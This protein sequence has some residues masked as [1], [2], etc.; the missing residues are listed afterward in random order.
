M[1]D[2]NSVRRFGF[3]GV[4]ASQ[5]SING[6]FPRWVDVWQL[7]D[8]T[9]EPHDVPL[10]AR[11]ERYRDIVLAIRD[12]PRHVGA[13]VTSHKVRL[14]DATRDLFDELDEHAELC[15]EVSCISKRNGR[16]IG[17]A[18]D[19]LTSG[20]SIEEFLAPGHFRRTGAD[21]VS[22]GAGGSGLAIAVYLLTGRKA[23]DRPRRITLVNRG[24][25]RLALCREVLLPLAG[26]TDL[27]FIANAD[28]VRNDALV[29]AS[30]P[31][32]LIVNATG[33]G[34]DRP[35]SP[36]TDAV[37]FPE[38][39]VAWELNYRGDL[40]FLQ[41]AEAQKERG[42]QVED[43]WRYFIHGWSAVIAEA[44]HIDLDD[45]ILQRLSAEA[46]AARS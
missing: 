15:R 9:F 3:V 33:L 46:E 29:G 16:L 5:S 21:V 31:G 17:H 45:R 42:V 24:E 20:R 41:Q 14:L 1:S 27:Q 23:G 34:K 26:G 4:T 36:L 28:P 11:P 19:P 10:D 37:E 30:R 18:K 38:N 43:G 25:P 6:V 35:G 13:L 12:D 2:R 39:A 8:V 22:L 40:K 32:S 44:F 7:G